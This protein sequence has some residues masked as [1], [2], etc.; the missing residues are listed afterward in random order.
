VGAAPVRR[1]DSPAARVSRRR[2]PGLSPCLNTAMRFLPASPAPGEWK[3][4]FVM[5]WKHLPCA[6]SGEQPL[7]VVRASTE[8]AARPVTLATVTCVSR[9]GAPIDGEQLTGVRRCMRL[10]KLPCAGLRRMLDRSPLQS[11]ASRDH[12]A[13]PARPDPAGAQCRMQRSGPSRP[14]LRRT[15]LAP[16]LGATSASATV[17]CSGTKLAACA[18]PR[19]SPGAHALGSLVSAAEATLDSLPHRL[20]AASDLLGRRTR[21]RS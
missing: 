16:Q 9:R 13:A 21:R 12:S 4:S 18:R 2:A 15:V 20:R 3:H 17:L 5:C 10:D 8:P 11:A 19:P 1:R 6:T 14:A 7:R